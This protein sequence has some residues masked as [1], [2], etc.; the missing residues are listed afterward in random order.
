MWYMKC[1]SYI[2]KMSLS[3][4][5]ST[6]TSYVE[7]N[8]LTQVTWRTSRIKVIKIHLHELDVLS[9]FALHGAYRLWRHHQTAPW[10]WYQIRKQSNV[11]RLKLH[12]RANIITATYSSLI[13]RHTNTHHSHRNSLRHTLDIH[14]HRH[15][16][17]S[18]WLHDPDYYL[19]HSHSSTHP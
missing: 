7:L 3:L 11:H 10:G 1:I 5:L 6:I 4:H 14:K 15:T 16:D 18:V 12:T 2:L 9:E 13:H 17:T 19:T 8:A